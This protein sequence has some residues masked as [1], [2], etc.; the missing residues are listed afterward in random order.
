MVRKKAVNNE[1]HIENARWFL[2]HHK[3]KWGKMK[4]LECKVRSMDVKAITRGLCS[5]CY[6][7]CYSKS[8]EKGSENAQEE[9]YCC[10]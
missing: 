8:H 6:E 5:I 10:P 7:K 2:Q 3:L 4:C 9:I 1:E